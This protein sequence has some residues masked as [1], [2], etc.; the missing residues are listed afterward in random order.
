MSLQ[1]PN[2][3]LRTMNFLSFR[4][5]GKIITYAHTNFKEKDKKDGHLLLDV[6]T[7]LM[8]KKVEVVISIQEHKEEPAKPDSEKKRKKY[9]FSNLYRKLEWKGDALK[10]KKKI[11]S[12]WD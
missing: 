2:Y 8:D 4:K 12:E 1:T 3:E 9:H 5:F 11:R 7:T 6:A 10:E